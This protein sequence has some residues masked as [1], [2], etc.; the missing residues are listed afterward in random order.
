M[1]I[2]TWRSKYLEQENVNKIGSGELLS[3][4]NICALL[5]INS[6]TLN[7]WVKNGEF[8]TPISKNGRTIGW[9]YSDYI[10]W[11]AI[12]SKRILKGNKPH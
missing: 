6:S 9:K 11:L 5:V 10:A 7:R 8:A 4:K 3:P 1:K 12:D 2:K